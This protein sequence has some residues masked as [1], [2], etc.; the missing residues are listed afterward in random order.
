MKA[1]IKKFLNIIPYLFLLT[2]FLLVLSVTLSVARG[3]TPQIFGKSFMIVTTTSME[4]TI[5]QGDVIM[6]DTSPDQIVVG[7]IISYYIPGGGPKDINTHRIV[8]IDTIDGVRYFT[9]IG[10]NNDFSLEWE[11]GFSEDYLIG[12]YVGKSS[13]VGDIYQFLFPIDGTGA[14]KFNIIFLVI[15]GVFIT[16]GGMEI[17][18]IIKQLS[19]AR[20]QKRLEEKEQ[21]VQEELEKLRKQEEKDK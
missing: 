13:L 15:I 14:Y 8:S 21:M 18:S 6:V 9:T 11:I 2:T 5:M 20:V 17:S 1:K 3:E 10:D 7:D 12:K 16:I 4:D 19:M